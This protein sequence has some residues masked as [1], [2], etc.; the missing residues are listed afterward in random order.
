MWITGRVIL[1][2]RGIHKRMDAASTSPASSSHGTGIKKQTVPGDGGGSGQQKQV[3][4]LFFPPVMKRNRHTGPVANGIGGAQQVL[5]PEFFGR[6]QGKQTQRRSILAFRRHVARRR[7][8]RRAT[9][10]SIHSRGRMPGRLGNP[11]RRLFDPGQS[12]H[13]FG[14]HRTFRTRQDVSIRPAE[15]QIQTIGAAEPL[16]DTAPFIIF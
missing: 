16:K 11:Y 12:V 4:G 9:S 15:D 8:S 3:R 2:T 5:K 10:V 6:R 1:L 7:V 14:R 13:D